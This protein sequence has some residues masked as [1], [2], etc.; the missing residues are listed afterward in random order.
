MDYSK[1]I[2]ELRLKARLTQGQLAEI[3]G[4]ETPNFISQ[5]ET[6]RKRV[7]L[8][9]ITK[10]CS[11]LG[12]EISDFFGN[13]Q[14]PNP[15]PMIPVMDLSS[16]SAMNILNAASRKETQG[17]RMI[18][19]PVDLKDEHAYGAVVRGDEMA[20]A[21][22]DRDV[23]FLAPSRPCRD[24]EIALVGLDTDEVLLREIRIKDKMLLLESFNP[25]VADRLVE[26]AE[27]EF[28]HPV[29][30]VR[31]HMPLSGPSP[32]KA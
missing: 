21:L 24:Q 31:Y 28:V 30:W 19:K 2:K 7:G 11:A 22:R 17:L 20:P 4:L 29:L 27:V 23:V 16:A 18:E 14:H 13:T 9:V 6:G 3:M 32:K 1:R 12:V 5:I 25:S 8:S 15:N 10:F 26:D